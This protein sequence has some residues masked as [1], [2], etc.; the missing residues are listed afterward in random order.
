METVDIVVTY[1]NDQDP[2]WRAAYDKCK[3]K[4]IKRGIIPA[5]SKQAFGVDR[6]RDWNTLKYWFRSVEKN[7]PWVRK[8][9]FVVWGPSQVPDWL[10]T[11]NPKLRIVYHN[12]FIPSRIT[13]VFCSRPIE[14]YT[15][16]IKD[17]SDKY[18]RC[19]DDCYFLNPVEESMFFRDGKPILPDNRRPFTPFTVYPDT[20]AFWQTFNNNMEIE[21]DFL[22]DKDY[23]Y[24]IHHLQTACDKKFEESIIKKY[25][26]KILKRCIY[27]HFRNQ[28]QYS[29]FLY[30]DLERLSGNAI[31]DDNIYKNSVYTWLKTDLNYNDLRTKQ[32]VCL[33]DTDKA[34]E[35]FDDIRRQQL[36]FFEIM[37]PDKSSFEK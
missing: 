33:N 1:L 23:T 37:F 28:H 15:C 3:D 31:V 2:V 20:A 24:G 34:N 29:I 35:K 14:L 17:L 19:N 4:E 18:I 7:C 9:F 16:K 8:I 12:E 32:C 22:G 30:D 25:G 13:P 36:D 26:S 6:M 5:S 21:K 10:D 27:S 11:T